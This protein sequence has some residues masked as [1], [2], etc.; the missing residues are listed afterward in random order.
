MLKKID[1]CILKPRIILLFKVC[2]TKSRCIPHKRRWIYIYIVLAELLYVVLGFFECRQIVDRHFPKLYIKLLLCTASSV[3]IHQQTTSASIERMR[4]LT[5]STLVFFFFGTILVIS[6]VPR[7]QRGKTAW[8]HLH[9]HVLKSFLKFSMTSMHG[10]HVVVHGKR[11]RKEYPVF[12]RAGTEPW[13]P[14]RICTF[15][16]YATWRRRI[17]LIV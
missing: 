9:V 15:V 7:P 11:V 1:I 12:K 2:S 8:Y 16:E 17:S 5:I 3:D 10:V 6:L 4:R 14:C 13:L